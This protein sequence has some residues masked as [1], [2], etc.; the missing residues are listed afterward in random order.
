[1]NYD[2][3]LDSD[4]HEAS[5]Y[6]NLLNDQAIVECIHPNVENMGFSLTGNGNLILRV[7]HF[8]IT[9]LGHQTYEAMNHSKIWSKINS[10]ILK[11]GDA[12]IKQIP[13]LGI[14]MITDNI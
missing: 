7:T 9:Y 14:K 10:A 1:M 4:L 6:M 2:S 12:G 8:R 13:A 5:F 11:L 3:N